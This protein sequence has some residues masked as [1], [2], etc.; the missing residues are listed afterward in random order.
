MLGR[1]ET[2]TR[3]KIYCQTIRTV[4]DIS[5]DDREEL[6]PAVCERRLTDTQTD[7]L[8]EN[9]SIDMPNYRLSVFTRMKWICT[10]YSMT[11]CF[12]LDNQIIVFD[13]YTV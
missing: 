10:P 11:T 8:N 3:D 1:T 13:N 5:R 12:F 2:R 9:Y 7:R 4:R 6:R